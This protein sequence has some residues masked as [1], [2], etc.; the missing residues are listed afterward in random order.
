MF[1]FSR[2]YNVCHSTIKVKLADLKQNNYDI[3]EG[4]IPLIFYW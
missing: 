3:I 2:F 4:Y 1:T